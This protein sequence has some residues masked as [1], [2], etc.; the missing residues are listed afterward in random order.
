MLFSCAHGRCGSFSSVRLD[1]LL[2]SAF[3]GQTSRC[4]GSQRSRA[5]HPC[6]RAL[7]AFFPR[8]SRPPK[9]STDDDADGETT[10]PP[11]RYQTYTRKLLAQ[12]PPSVKGFDPSNMNEFDTFVAELTFY[13]CE[14]AFILEL[15]TTHATRFKSPQDDPQYQAYLAAQRLNAEIE[16]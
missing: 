14:V 4:C 13:L 10:T 15:A 1:K 16:D 8:I 11:P 9:K 2:A 3:M 6:F 5:K 12:A 7:T